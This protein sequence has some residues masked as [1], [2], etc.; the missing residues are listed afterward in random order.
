MRVA[1]SASARRSRRSRISVSSASISSTKPGHERAADRAA[2][3]VERVG[4]AGR[5]ARARA[6]PAEP[7]QRVRDLDPV[8][9]AAGQRRGVLEAAPPRPRR[10]R[11][12]AAR[13]RRRRTPS[14]WAGAR[15]SPRA[16][17]VASDSSTSRSASSSSPR[18]ACATASSAI[19]N[20]R[21]TSCSPGGPRPGSPRSRRLRLAGRA[22]PEQA[23]GEEVRVAAAPPASLGP[24]RDGRA[25][26]RTASPMSRHARAA[27]SPTGAPGRPPGRRA[28]VRRLSARRLLGA[29]EPRL[30]LL[31]RPAHRSRHAAARER[32][33][34]VLG[35][36]SRRQA[37]DPADRLVRQPVAV[38]RQPVAVQHV[39]GGLHVAGADRV[40]DRAAQVAAA[41]EPRARAPVQVGDAL[42]RVPLEL[43]EQHG[44]EQGVVAIPAAGGVERDDEEVAALEGEQRRCAVARSTTASHRSLERRSSTA[45]RIRKSRVSGACC[46]TTSSQR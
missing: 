6:A 21:R 11:A 36:R 20:T 25:G 44:A 32:Q 8:A 9:A 19:A 1:R 28:R 35:D 14:R 16:S 46:A 23:H 41:G 33:L 31:G 15:S 43:P 30:D 45:V 22:G 3:G 29:R 18:A 38:E 37:V 2:G 4:R 24:Q 17:V 12:P 5:V 40:L 39:G 10:P 13:S 34:W 42:R 26:D 7:Q 27:T